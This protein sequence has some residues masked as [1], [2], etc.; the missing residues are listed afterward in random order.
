MTN[1]MK[2][3]QWLRSKLRD[4]HGAVVI[5]L[6]DRLLKQQKIDKDTCW[7]IHALHWAR[8]QLIN[9]IKVIDANSNQGSKIRVWADKITVIDFALQEQWGWPQDIKKHRWWELPGCDCNSEQNQ[10]W[11]GTSKRFMSDDC[12]Y[13]GHVKRFEKWWNALDA[14]K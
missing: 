12:V 6:N 4:W 1:R 3:P 14:V 7:K 9:E 5:E 10:R 13:H 2:Y 8:H 11:L